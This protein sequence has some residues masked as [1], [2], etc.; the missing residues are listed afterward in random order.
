MHGL[1]GKQGL[2]TLAWD[3]EGGGGG[4]GGITSPVVRGVVHIT[5]SLFLLSA[6]RK[7][8]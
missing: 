8:K 7:Q 2:V 4:R 3:D 5:A 6:E 1:K